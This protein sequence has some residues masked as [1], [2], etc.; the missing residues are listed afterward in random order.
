LVIPTASVLAV[1]LK[2][3]PVEVGAVALKLVGVPGAAVSGSVLKLVAV[4]AFDAT[5]E[6]SIAIIEKL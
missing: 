4:V 5:P 3:T 1:Q 6:L 2:L